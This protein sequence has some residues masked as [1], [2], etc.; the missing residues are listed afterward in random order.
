MAAVAAMLRASINATAAICP[1][2]GL[3]PSRLGKFR[4]LCRIDRPL[5]P[6]VSPAPKQGPQKAVF[7]TAPA[8]IRSP[9]IPFFIKSMYTGR[10]EGYTFRANSP[11]PMERP[12]S[13]ADASATLE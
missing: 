5:L 13:R 7:T 2:P 8:A 1:W 3:D 10:E 9:S 11:L 4:V 12:R 6:G